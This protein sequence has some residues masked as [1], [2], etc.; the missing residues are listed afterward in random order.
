M[1]K[2]YQ[3]IPHILAESNLLDPYSFRVLIYLNRFSPSFPQVKTIAKNTRIAERQVYKSLKILEELKFI[4]I[5]KLNRHNIYEIDLTPDSLMHKASTTV[6]RDASLRGM[7]DSQSCETCIPVMSDMTNSHTNKNK[8]NK[9]K[10]LRP[11]P[12]DG[13]ANSRR[14][15]EIL[16]PLLN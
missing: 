15:S 11:K 2:P 8:N 16:S 9:N 4:K 14:I 5:S 1:N 13:Q 7:A 10:I 3:Q 12:L 6:S